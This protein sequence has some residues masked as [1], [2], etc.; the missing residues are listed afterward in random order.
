M[1]FAQEKKLARR[2]GCRWKP[3]R[4]GRLGECLAHP[5]GLKCPHC[6]TAWAC[7]ELWPDYLRYPGAVCNDYGHCRGR[8]QIFVDK[9]E[10]QA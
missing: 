2:Q 3:L 8:L 10:S 9:Q 7:G 1:T 5:K 6:G 4:D